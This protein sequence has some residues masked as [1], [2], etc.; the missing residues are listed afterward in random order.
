MTMRR[1]VSVV[2]ALCG[3]AGVAGTADFG[4]AFVYDGVPF[5]AR[6]WMQEGKGRFV[7]PDGKLVFGA[8]TR[9]WTETPVS[10]IRPFLE[11][12]EKTG[13]VERFTSAVLTLPL[14]GETVRIRRIQGSETKANDDF[15]RRDVVLSSDRPF[16]SME[17]T[18]GWP[19][20]RF[21]PYLGVDLDA[22]NGCEIAVGWTGAWRADFRI[23][24]GA[25]KVSFPLPRCRFAMRAGERF[26]L[27]RVLVYRRQGE[28]RRMAEVRYHRF[29]IAEKSPRG[30][31]GRLAG[32]ALPWALGEQERGDE[33]AL[34]QLA[35]LAR[36]PELPF[37][38]FWIDAGWY[39]PPQDTRGEDIANGFWSRAVGDWRV[40]TA[41]H[42]DG[43]LRR[44]SD[45]CHAQGKRFMLWIEPE[46]AMAGD[47]LQEHPEWFRRGD[48][49]FP[50]TG[51][52]RNVR[53]DEP[54][55][56]TAIVERVDRII[57]ENGVDIYRQ[58][59][60]MNILEG[61]RRD[62]PSDRQGANEIRY[63]NALWA[64]WDE[65]KR[66]HPELLFDN[67]ASGGKRLDYEM[68][69]RS[70]SY[71]R[72]DALAGPAMPELAQAINLNITPFVPF[73]GGPLPLGRMDDD[74]AMLSALSPTTAFVSQGRN[75]DYEALL[76]K[77]RKWA[78]LA[79]R[80]RELFRGDFY[81][82][83]ENFEEFPGRL[84]NAYQLHL[85]EE[86]RGVFAVFRQR[87]SMTESL[88]LELEGIDRDSDYELET[89]DGRTSVVSGRDLIR[90]TSRL[91]KPRS[92][93]M[94]FYRKR[95]GA[96]AG[97]VQKVLPVL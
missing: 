29:M 78:V 6:T 73:S 68:N 11:A 12:R 43:N 18:T 76:P 9:S 61:L 59:F 90:W 65:L 55:V 40:N 71:W 56:W 17:E 5:D 92:A 74:Y 84:T 83:T 85:P 30:R 35:F 34:R 37:D 81:C 24:D 60:N 66:R 87:Y 7:S 36:H 96:G 75:V 79:S 10:E 77:I 38:A 62:E 95:Q 51:W 20:R 21:L 86:G 67:C 57:T 23:V 63:V 14:R 13:L 88:T 91:P 97:A 52:L 16:L 44:I 72:D 54:A 3:L 93:E 28:S 22:S 48:A 32:P 25:L 8:E 4:T 39:G 94:V 33:A 31:D 46:R 45:A 49:G 69:A 53:L 50:E 42:P 15:R 58:D 1:L 2:F 82:L 26:E 64:F 80:L 70:A 89:C 47:L 19:S 41:I 27:P